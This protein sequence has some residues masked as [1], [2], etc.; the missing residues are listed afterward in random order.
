MDAYL[1][2]LKQSE[3]DKINLLNNYENKLSDNVEVYME[4]YKEYEKY[5]KLS[6]DLRNQIA[7]Y[8]KNCP[9]CQKVIEEITE[10]TTL[11]GIKI[12]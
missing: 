4:L 8:M 3:D 11:N 12:K 6:E 7:I 1:K 9:I 10:E 2:S 5:K